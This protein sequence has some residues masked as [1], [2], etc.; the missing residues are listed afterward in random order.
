MNKLT[1]IIATFAVSMSMY[2][3]DSCHISKNDNYNPQAHCI[4][5]YENF[6]GGKAPNEHRKF[7][8]RRCTNQ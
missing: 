8:I 7:Y 5:T 3:C 1:K 6:Y 2:G 4:R